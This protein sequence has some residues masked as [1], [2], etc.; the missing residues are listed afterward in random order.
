M[1]TIKKVMDFYATGKVLGSKPKFWAKA[2]K[3][4]TSRGIF[5]RRTLDW[6]KTILDHVREFGYIRNAHGFI[7]RDFRNH[8]LF[9]DLFVRLGARLREFGQLSAEEETAMNRVVYSKQG[10]VPL[11]ESEFARAWYLSA[12]LEIGRSK[13]LSALDDIAKRGAKWWDNLLPDRPPQSS[14]NH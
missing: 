9:E 10:P 14:S 6:E 12:C 13:P 1:N 4:A 11:L 8:E 3:R 7:L 2:S 5:G